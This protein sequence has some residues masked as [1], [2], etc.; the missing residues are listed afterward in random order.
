MSVLPE[1]TIRRLTR[2]LQR[3]QLSLLLLQ[4]QRHPPPNNNSSNKHHGQT[5][6]IP[7]TVL[8]GKQPEV[9]YPTTHT[10]QQHPPTRNLLN[11]LPRPTA[12]TQQVQS[13][14]TQ[15]PKPISPP[16]QSRMNSQQARKQTASHQPQTV[17]ATAHPVSMLVPLRPG[18]Q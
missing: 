12:R 11:K 15:L 2:I 7:S 17:T 5:R 16:A 13:S 4:P 3:R 10:V 9:R 6:I 14:K 8:A 18:G 1:L